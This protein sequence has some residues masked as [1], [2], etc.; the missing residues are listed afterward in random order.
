M[1][2]FLA[3]ILLVICALTTSVFA[4]CSEPTY[5]KLTYTEAV[6]VSYVSEIKNGAQVLDGATV[7]FKLDLESYVQ[8]TPVVKA[9][10]E[11]LTPDASGTYSFVMS[12]DVTITVAELETIYK[13]VVFSATPGVRFTSELF[14]SL[15][16]S[17]GDAVMV[18]ALNGTPVTFGI[19]LSSLVEGTPVVKV[20]ETVLTADVNGLYTF[21]VENFNNDTY[22]ISV[23]GIYLK[24]LC[25][26]N[27]DYYQYAQFISDDIDVE[28]DDPVVEGTV[29]KFDVKESVYYRS[30][31]EVTANGEILARGTDGKYSVTITEN[32]TVQIL[33][34][35]TDYNFT[36]R[37]DGGR[38][39]IDDPYRI[40]RPI[41][42]YMLSVLVNN[43][44]Y[45][46]TYNG[47]YFE[48]AND[49]DLNGEQLFIIGD[50]TENSSYFQGVFDGN[51][52]TISNFFISD[53]IIEQ[54]NFTE[55][56]IPTIG[57]FGY[58]APG[59]TISNLKLDNFTVDIDADKYDTSFYAGGIVGFA[60]GAT[61]SGC[62]VTNAR[63]NA[64][65]D[66]GYFGYL[67]GVAGVL[68][69][70]FDG[71]STRSYATISSCYSD[72]TLRVTSGYAY[73]AGGIVGLLASYEEKTNA[74]VLNSY[75]T[76]SVSGALYTGG[77]A[78]RLD[79]ETCAIGCYNVGNV[80]SQTTIL[81][82][83]NAEADAFAYAYAGGIAG[84]ADFN[85]VVADSFS[86]GAVNASAASGSN[87][88]HKGDIVGLAN[89]GGTP[90]VNSR[91]SIISN[92]YGKDNAD[93]SNDFLKN[94]L[95][96][97][98]SDWVFNNDG[99]PTVN[100]DETHKTFTITINYNGETVA[101]ESSISTDI[102]DMYI[103]MSYWYIMTDELGDEYVIP[104]FAVSDSGK[105][106]YGYYFDANLTKR[107]P[108]S[109]VPTCDVTLYVGW[110]DYSEVVG[111]YYVKVDGRKGSNVK[112]ELETD[113]TLRFID[114]ARIVDSTYVYDGEKIILLDTAI[115]RVANLSDATMIENAETYYY[116][117]FARVENGL[118][119]AWDNDYFP[120]GS[121]L[122]ALKEIESFVYGKYVAN[123][124]N[125]TSSVYTFNTDGTGTISGSINA[126]FT[127]VIN[128]NQISIDR[129]G[130]IRNG[131]IENGYVVSV[132]NSPL[133][134]IDNFYGVW[135]TSASIH[136]KFSFDGNS[137]WT[138]ESYGYNAN[139][140]K[141]N[142][143]NQEGSYEIVG[144]VLVMD[145]GY[146]AS[147][148]GNG[149][150]KVTG[151]DKNLTLYRENSFV[152]TWRYSHVKEPVTIKLYGI[153]SDGYGIASITFSVNDTFEA[154]YSS[155]GRT[156]TVYNE[157]FAISTLN[158][159]TATNTLVGQCFSLG[160]YTIR[161]NAK[162]CLYDDF[163]G[164][165]VGNSEGFEEV[166]FNGYGG[167][168][169]AGSKEDKTMAVNGVVRIGENSVRYVINY[170]DNTATFTYNDVVYTAKHNYFSNK[171]EIT[172]GNNEVIE[173]VKHDLWMNRVLVGTNDEG[174]VQYEITFDGKGL[175]SSGGKL[176][177]TMTA[178]ESD[179]SETQE[180]IYKVDGEIVRL[181]QVIDENIYEF[182]TIE[183]KDGK[184]A[185]I[186]GGVENMHLTIK[187]A[188]TGEWLINGNR[189]TMTIGQIGSDLTACGSYLSEN[190]EFV[191]DETNGTLTFT[192]A[193]TTML[194][195]ALSDGELFLS[196]QG[197]N[198]ATIGAI[199]IDMQDSWKGVFVSKDGSTYYEFDGFAN[200]KYTD[201]TAIVKD[202]S[203]NVTSVYTYSI[204]V[205][206]DVLIKMGLY[207]Y[208]LFI[209][210][211]CA[212]NA[213]AYK[214]DD[215][216]YHVVAIDDFYLIEGTDSDGNTY[217]FDG[218]GCVISTSED[219]E[220]IT[221]YEY[222]IL[223][224]NTQERVY[225]LRFTDN[226]GNTYTV[227]FDYKDHDN[228]VLTIE[229]DEE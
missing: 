191:Y 131:V 5:Y 103:P 143:V 120:Q 2:K 76:G 51:G 218:V 88:A 157:D 189:G 164:N 167:Y 44:Y 145:N 122:T 117:F 57:M 82:T 226:L 116:S 59:A 179:E 46:G 20:G 100:Y 98:E 74:F 125:N 29:I 202:S 73:A 210:C 201:A 94:T 228:Y 159:N 124:A 60:T 31:Y 213:D 45:A 93:Y 32:T 186:V 130:V 206:G 118:L 190:V 119:K 63:F 87:F 106:S 223:Q 140:Q 178:V 61:I 176:T 17:E 56:F 86:V 211:D 52:Y 174:N 123:G 96:W 110:A 154:T 152:G 229:Q 126:E 192:Y 97:S 197:M 81:E 85:T 24:K 65:A 80:S 23:E 135:E 144:G 195:S 104:E 138:Y 184:Y 30:D 58:V 102:S 137:S 158:Y 133:I 171:I 39:T 78:G 27:F 49:I 38:G 156:V 188:F 227:T 47:C 6:G 66:L 105:R 168:D 129:N 146:S 224:N 36:E 7:S 175:L 77:I 42:L 220:T 141:V 214:K 33:G 177:A 83:G 216:W 203:G 90:Y 162:F 62:S 196:K 181:Y 132:Q 89:V 147:F 54:T 183:A 101:E 113:G 111:T 34:L 115:A 173:L 40:S 95:N 18:E 205:N 68:Q 9:G 25:N 114:G 107:V 1:K 166:V 75:F 153:G 37:E 222:E 8:G 187:N 172:Y 84:Y 28:G 161:N 185:F 99:Y 15:T 212:D 10:E 200:S 91:A 148:D 221:A 41:D 165:W 151:E 208:K 108:Y 69:S 48:L 194:V 180:F 12:G 92:C 109:F 149:N 70:Y 150:I 193:G 225:T 72:A 64:D 182:A 21:T 170:A 121:E 3:T 199:K 134:P 71:S 55:I 155:N 217:M 50:Q 19:E 53:T 35:E 16:P 112:L 204:D 128:G 14:E 207:N 215:V 136:E 4:S 163:G 26:V 67:G 79:G 169:I 11:V 219:G 127:Y 160:D 22:V 198:S 209:E 142:E 43:S 139:G 13:G